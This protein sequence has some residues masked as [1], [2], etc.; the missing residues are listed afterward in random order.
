MR[1]LLLALSR[2]TSG[3]GGAIP[4]LTASPKG[5]LSHLFKLCYSHV[6]EWASGKFVSSPLEPV[7]PSC[8]FAHVPKNLAVPAPN[9]KRIK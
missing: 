1:K 4:I 3:A 2:A 5:R 6:S 8:M 9:P 7:S